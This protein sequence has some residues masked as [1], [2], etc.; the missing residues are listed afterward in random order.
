MEGICPSLKHV[1]L[2]GVK[3]QGI[4]LFAG[5]L[6]LL[7]STAGYVMSSFQFC[8][9]IPAFGKLTG[10][11]YPVKLKMIFYIYEPIVKTM[12]DP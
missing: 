8:R 5:M 4:I 3:L 2:H 10:S 11:S 9:H 12:W 1:Y 7:F 6:V